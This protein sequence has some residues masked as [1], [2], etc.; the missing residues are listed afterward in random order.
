MTQAPSIGFVN[1][2]NLVTGENWQATVSRG[3]QSSSSSG[4]GTG[5]RAT[6]YG[7]QSVLDDVPNS[8]RVRNTFI[9]MPTGEGR[10]LRRVH[11]DPM[12]VDVAQGIPAIS[13][14]SLSLDENMPDAPGSRPLHWCPIANCSRNMAGRRQPF[15]SASA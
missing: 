6:P 13:M 4:G 1:G 9:D 2:G 8:I 3:G 12:T 15:V 5:H 14:A 7:P 10:Q 11:T